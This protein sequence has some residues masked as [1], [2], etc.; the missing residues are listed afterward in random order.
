MFSHCTYQFGM[1]SLFIREKVCD[2]VGF[3]PGLQILTIIALSS[4]LAKPA[5]PFSLA[6]LLVSR[7]FLRLVSC[8]TFESGAW[9][10]LAL[11]LGWSAKRFRY[12]FGGP[13]SPG[14]ASRG[15]LGSLLTPFHSPHIKTIFG[16]A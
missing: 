8:V 14:R 6:S 12:L 11:S 15:S 4:T 13:V 2:H 7:A 1:F 5:G 3:W 16:V 10:R 9:A